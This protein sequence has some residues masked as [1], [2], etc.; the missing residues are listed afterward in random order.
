M[1][2]S[3]RSPERP[4]LKAANTIKRIRDFTF[5]SLDRTTIQTHSCNVRRA[6]LNAR[7]NADFGLPSCAEI[8][9]AMNTT[10]ANVISAIARLIS[11]ATARAK[12]SA[13]KPDPNDLT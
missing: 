11:G 1:L 12:T 5:Q 13:N 8:E 6:C 2:E 9:L 10:R 4:Q 3:K 7:H